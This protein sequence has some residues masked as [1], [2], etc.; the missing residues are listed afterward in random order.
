MRI[1]KESLARVKEE[2]ERKR[3]ERKDNIY[4][5]IRKPMFWPVVDMKQEERFKIRS[6]S[7][8]KFV[9]RVY[10]DFIALRVLL[11]KER[12][13]VVVPKVPRVK[14]AS[15]LKH[16]LR[17]LCVHPILRNLENVRSF[18][19]SEDEKDFMNRDV[20][21]TKDTSLSTTEDDEKRES[22]GESMRKNQE[23]KVRCEEAQVRV[24]GISNSIQKREKQFDQYCNCLLYTF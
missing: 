7:E 10:E 23:I 12:P 1:A 5:R 11:L 3:K 19:T 13:D 18:L 15:Y 17:Y 4:P 2:I 21:M 14:K 8:K 9:R 6:S 20:N 24:E 16:F 22:V